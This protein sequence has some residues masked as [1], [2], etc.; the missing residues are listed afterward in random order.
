MDLKINQ[1][2]RSI[3]LE[4]ETPEDVVKVAQKLA[5]EFG[6]I[7]LGIKTINFSVG[8][9]TDWY[10]PST[11]LRGITTVITALG[12]PQSDPQESS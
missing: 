2:V 7:G 8:F 11:E 6:D 3:E 10:H 9:K 4:I 1:K 5:K 12:F